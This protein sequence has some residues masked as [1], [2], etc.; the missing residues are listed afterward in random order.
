MTRHWFP[1][2]AFEEYEA[3]VDWI[4]ARA[5]NQC[6]RCTAPNYMH[7]FHNMAGAFTKTT[8]TEPPPWLDCPPAFTI[9][10]IQVTLAHLDQD[11]TNND[12]ENLAFLCQ[13]CHPNFEPRHELRGLEYEAKKLI[14]IRAEIMTRKM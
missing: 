9:K 1:S 3:I 5:R 10:K 7:G 2:K 4:R 14:R 6:E 13:R 8:Q 12:P 11:V